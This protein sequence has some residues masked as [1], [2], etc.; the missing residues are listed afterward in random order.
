MPSYEVPA[1]SEMVNVDRKPLPGGEDYKA[2]ILECAESTGPNFDG[3]IVD[4]LKVKFGITAFAD[5]APLEDVT[6]EKLEGERWAWK[7]FEP[8]R[9]GF[10]QNGTPSLARQFFAAAIGLANITDRFPPFDTDDFKG[11]EVILSLIVKNGQNGQPKN[12]ITAIKPLG[13]RRGGAATGAKAQA[14]VSPEYAAAV[15]D[16]VADGAKPYVASEGEELP[17]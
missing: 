17:F 4:Q 16:L 15:A 9:L 6:G 5:G 14:A 12:N 8:K 1:Q 7:D 13:R 2:T 10:Q 3:E 11:R